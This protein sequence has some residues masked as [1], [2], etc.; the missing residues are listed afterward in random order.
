MLG[1]QTPQSAVEQVE[2]AH[3][4]VEGDEEGEKGHHGGGEHEVEEVV[5]AGE[6]E[7][8][9][10]EAAHGGGDEDAD[11]CAGG[12]DDA[13][14]V[15]DGEV[16]AGGV[17]DHQVGFQGPFFRQQR[18][19][20]TYDIGAGLEGGEKEPDEGVEHGEAEE[21]QDE[22]DDDFG[23][24]SCDQPATDGRNGGGLDG[25]VS[26]CGHV[27][28]RVVFKVCGFQWKRL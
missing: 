8:G 22:K 19:R 27:F 2:L 9:E 25:R 1:T 10:D 21:C 4:D 20:Q 11:D 3:D 16:G 26:G 6:L 28:V 7:A 17:H 12:D 23:P 5:A 14:D 15:G 18:D 13:V 24:F